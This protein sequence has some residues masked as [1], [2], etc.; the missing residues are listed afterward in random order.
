MASTPPELL[1]SRLAELPSSL[2]TKTAAL[3]RQLVIEALAA[4]DTREHHYLV[5]AA[6]HEVGAVTVSE[7]A[8]DIGLDR[9][10]V[11]ATV[12]LLTRRGYVECTADHT[13]RRRI[14]LTLTL[15]GRQHLDK[16]N[17]LLLRAQA[18]LLTDLSNREQAQLIRLL[19]AVLTRRR[20]RP[21]TRLSTL[22]L[23]QPAQSRTSATP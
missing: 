12:R 9:A 21:A 15:T 14:L 18:E 19:T 23:D 2:M 3:A 13:D 4:G 16:L 20:R 22:L 5:L 10:D 7:L 1:P 17:Q 6:L 11:T 8:P